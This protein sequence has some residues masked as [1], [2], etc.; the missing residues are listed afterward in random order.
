[1]RI[2]WTE[3]W[4]KVTPTQNTLLASYTIFPICF[5]FHVIQLFLPHA[6]TFH[7]SSWII[8]VLSRN[9]ILDNLCILFESY[10]VDCLSDDRLTW[11]RE[12]LCH[13]ETQWQEKWDREVSWSFSSEVRK[14][15][16]NRVKVI[17]IHGEP[18][19]KASAWYF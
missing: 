2:F 8:Q 9:L 17:S 13:R 12:V 10:A 4:S 18:G 14:V 6:S 5:S 7:S 11:K 19:V 1:M 15:Q 16:G 3:I